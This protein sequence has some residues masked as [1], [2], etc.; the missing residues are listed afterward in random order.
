MAGAIVFVLIVVASLW[1]LLSKHF[2]HLWAMDRYR[3]LVFVPIAVVLIVSLRIGRDWD[4][5]SALPW[6]WL[7]VK[8]TAVTAA[9]SQQWLA[10]A[11]LLLTVA[12]LLA[13]PWISA[14]S[15]VL[16]V[17]ATFHQVGRKY[18]LSLMPAWL[19]LWLLMPLP[20]GAGRSAC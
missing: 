17:R 1:P 8:P 3:C 7:A 11:W 10:A 15:G 14:V 18:G 6:H 9:T 4:W 19:L 2:I 5:D 12:V 16:A 20:S 13:S